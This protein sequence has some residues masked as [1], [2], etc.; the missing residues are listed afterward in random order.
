[1]IFR[2]LTLASILGRSPWWL[3]YYIITFFVCQAFVCKLFVNLGSFSVYSFQPTFFILSHLRAFVNPS[4]VKDLWTSLRFSD[5][6]VHSL[7]LLRENLSLFLAFGSHLCLSLAF[8]SLI[9]ISPFFPLVNTFFAFFWDLV[10]W[11]VYFSTSHKI[12][13]NLLIFS[14]L[15]SILYIS[16][17]NL[18]TFMLF[19]A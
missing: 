1:M 12:W 14:F 2:S 3:I 13:H 7:G 18:H 15:Y 5:V 11:T 16:R 19:S 8:D 9:I 6:T 17:L 10:G 4:F